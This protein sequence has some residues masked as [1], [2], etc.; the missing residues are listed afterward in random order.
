LNIKGEPGAMEEDQQADPSEEVSQ[1]LREVGRRRWSSSRTHDAETDVPPQPSPVRRD[2]PLL[3]R[4][5]L[6]ALLLVVGLHYVYTYT[7]LEILSL[8]SLL[9]FVFPS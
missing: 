5:L 6:L 7:E 1:W 9:V 8:H 2:T 4:T 3:R